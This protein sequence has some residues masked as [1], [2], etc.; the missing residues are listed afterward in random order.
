MP[1]YRRNIGS[2]VGERRRRSGDEVSLD[3]APSRSAVVPSRVW[4][5][6]AWGRGVAR[7]RLV[8]VLDGTG[9]V[10]EHV[11]RPADGPW[12]PL[13]LGDRSNVRLVR[14]ICDSRTYVRHGAL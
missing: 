13:P 8:D 4:T 10:A 2:R 9:E 11:G 5:R 7:E 1:G 6:S 12:P 14:E 3:A